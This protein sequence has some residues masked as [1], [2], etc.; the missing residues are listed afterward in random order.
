MYRGI[1]NAIK[2]RLDQATDD[3]SKAIEIKPD[4]S[5]TLKN[6]AKLYCQKSRFDKAIIDLRTVMKLKPND[7]EAL[8]L[9]TITQQ[10]EVEKKAN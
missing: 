3:L 2:G 9:L 10:K 4:D 1:G 6:R 8:E 7:A 5:E